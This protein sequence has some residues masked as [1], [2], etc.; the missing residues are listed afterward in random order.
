MNVFM[1]SIMLFATKK[2]H[3]YQFSRNY[4]RAKL[5]VDG[6]GWGEGGGLKGGSGIHVAGLWARFDAADRKIWG[7]KS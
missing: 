5:E 7:E 1:V 6:V 3:L 2:Y 4:F